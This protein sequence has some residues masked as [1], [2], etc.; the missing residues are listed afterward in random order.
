MSALAP[1]AMALPLLAAA[2]LVP[3]SSVLRRRRVL[4]AGAILVAAAVTGLCVAMLVHAGSGIEVYW[5]GGWG[6]RHGGPCRAV[7]CAI[8]VDFAVDQAGAAMATLAALLVTA[9]LLFTWRYFE[10]VGTLYHVLMLAFCSAMVGFS[11]TGDLFDL[12]VFFELM[13]VTAYALTAYRIED[14]GPVQ[15]ALNFAISNSVG[16]YLVLTGI[17]LVYARTGALNL[18]QIG[19]TLTG[20]LDAVVVV[21][22][23]LITVGFLVKAAIVPFH[24]WLADAH[25]AA[26]TPACVLFSGVMVELGLYAVAR[27]YATAFAPAFGAHAGAV[28]GAFLALGAVTAVAGAVMCL[29]Q[30][31]VKRLLAFSTV[32]HAG[33]FLCGLSLLTPLGLAGTGVYVL[34]HGLVKG[35][36]FLGAGI[37]L[38][39]FRRID[40]PHLWGRARGMPVTAALFVVAALALAGMPPF[41]TY[42]GKGLVDTAGLDAGLRWLPAL[43]VLAS[44]L[45][46][47]A[48][49]RMAA[50][51]F[52]GLG[53]RPA[54]D[55][56]SESEG[57]EEESGAG[58]RA[59]AVMV[60][61]MAG[62]LAI[63]A[64]AGLLPVLHQQA[65]A[66]AAHLLDAAG[67]AR[68]VLGGGAPALSGGGRPQTASD[69]TPVDVL[70]GLVAAVGAVAVAAAGLHRHRLPVLRR[71]VPGWVVGPLHA[72]RELQSGD[73]RDYVAWLV[74]G[75]GVLGGALALATLR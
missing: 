33:L 53:E 51:V 64:V 21:A 20:R 11:L 4:D 27:V 7:A 17:G 6:P 60:L 50:R 40:V 46:G 47:G 14:P 52:A 1:V 58:G 56:T 59:P 44:A 42:A 70:T 55:P 75:T 19:Q 32:S 37:L 10:T 57:E 18:A 38:H 12:F 63:A 65:E 48:V 22:F 66:G 35:A 34:G 67:Y 23:V 69:L 68:A 62:L 30:E 74:L 15:G 45:T 25:A 31:H 49:L 72:L 24:F 36:L 3:L 73:V 13:S 8:G 29:L 16:A 2:V 54:R 28:R 5:F 61:P 39:R 71:S 41:A 26:P 9:A 43:L